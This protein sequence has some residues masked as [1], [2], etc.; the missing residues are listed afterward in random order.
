MGNLVAIKTGGTFED[1]AAGRG[2]FEDWILIGMA[3]AKEGAIIVDVCHGARLPDYESVSGIVITGS[4]DMVTQH[5]DWSESVAGWLS[6]AV[7]RQI[8]TLGIC[9]GHQLLAY[10]MGGSVG[11]NP[12]GMEC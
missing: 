10:A 4:H 3:L 1:I 9:Y 2:D 8:P 12:N 5:H 6:G 7:E 11:N